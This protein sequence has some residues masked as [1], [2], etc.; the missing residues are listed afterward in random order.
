MHVLEGNVSLRLPSQ[1][2][3]EHSKFCVTGDDV[4]T[5]SLS[6]LIA[7]LGFVIL[8]EPRAIVLVPMI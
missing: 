6:I 4:Y 8:P 5:P 1:L 3:L 7:Q 2:S